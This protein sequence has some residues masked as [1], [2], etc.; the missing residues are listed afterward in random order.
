MKTSEELHA[1]HK[2]LWGWLAET[3]KEKKDWPGWMRKDVVFF[4]G[5]GRFDQEE[6]NHCFACRCALICCANCPLDFPNIPRDQ[7]CFCETE[8]SPL[9]G[10][11]SAITK[12][13]KM[14]YA[15][16]IRDLPWSER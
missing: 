2:E 9:D 4:V 15:A 6:W 16:I 7:E 10:W 13:E 12:E 5:E 11:Y 3:G 1:L 14:E 8:G